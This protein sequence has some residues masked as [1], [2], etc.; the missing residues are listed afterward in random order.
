MSRGMLASHTNASRSSFFEVHGL[1]IN[2]SPHF[3]FDAVAAVVWICVGMLLMGVIK[4]E[5]VVVVVNVNPMTIAAA[6]L[7]VWTYI[8]VMR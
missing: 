3:H 7:V 1:L 2:I 6:Y 5:V 4:M 8:R